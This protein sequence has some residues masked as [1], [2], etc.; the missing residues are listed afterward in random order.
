MFFGFDEALGM[1]VWSSS[2]LTRGRA[3]HVSARPGANA[4][5]AGA[6]ARSENGARSGRESVKSPVARGNLSVPPGDGRSLLGDAFRTCQESNRVVCARPTRSWEAVFRRSTR[7]GGQLAKMLDAVDTR[8]VARSPA[9]RIVGG[10]RKRRH[11]A[12]RISLPRP[13]P[14]V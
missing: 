12:G 3:G 7:F 10:G 4:G 6:P 5:C 11:R 8:G 14:S 2:E 1:A 9:P 13:R